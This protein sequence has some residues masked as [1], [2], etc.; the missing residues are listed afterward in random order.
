MQHCP[1]L[2]VLPRSSHLLQKLFEV[3][4]LAV[5]PIRKQT[6]R[7]VKLHAQD[8]AVGVR[9]SPGVFNHFLSSW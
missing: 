8:R 6:C 9:L 3:G 1:W 2:G 5:L 4:A 7:E